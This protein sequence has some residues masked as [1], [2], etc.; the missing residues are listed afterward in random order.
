MFLSDNCHVNNSGGDSTRIQQLIE[1]PREYKH[2]FLLYAATHTH[3]YID[4]HTYGSTDARRCQE[5]TMKLM[6]NKNVKKIKKIILN[7]N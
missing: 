7:Q 3:T 6:K 1:C 2:Q 4:K 5:T